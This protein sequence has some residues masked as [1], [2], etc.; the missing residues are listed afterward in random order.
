MNKRKFKKQQKRQINN[1]INILKKKY[2]IVIENEYY[3]DGILTFKFKQLPTWLFGISTGESWYLEGEG[4]INL[5][6][7]GQNIYTLDKFKPSRSEFCF[8]DLELDEAVNTLEGMFIDGYGIY[9][10]EIYE[11]AIWNKESQMETNEIN[12]QNLFAVNKIINDTPDN[13]I[14]YGTKNRYGRTKSGWGSDPLWDIEVFTDI[15][16]ETFITS[17]IDR[18]RRLIH[19]AL[20]YDN[21]RD[22]VWNLNNF[23]ME[24]T[25]GQREYISYSDYEGSK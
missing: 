24:D 4:D 13:G 2:P 20:V 21:T 14:F 22:G 10:E 8:S 25:N 1:L 7:Y 5:N 16:D 9:K 11:E 18:V 15:I 3:S 12:A 17:E 23:T 6:W 19:K